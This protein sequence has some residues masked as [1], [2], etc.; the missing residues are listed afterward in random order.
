V[1]G[2][3]R[4][5]LAA[6][7]LALGVGALARSAHAEAAPASPVPAPAVAES[8]PA[9]DAADETPSENDSDGYTPPAEGPGAPPSVVVGGYVDVGFARAQGDGTSFAPGDTRLPADYG[10]D[11][12]ATAVNSRGDVASTDSHG[13]LVNGFLPHSVGIG[14]HPSFLVNTV[15]ADLKYAPPSTPLTMFTRVLVLP[16][17]SDTGDATRVVVEQAFGR[18]IPFDALEAA[19]AVGKF[20]S[21]FGIE[22][23][24]NESNIRTGITPSLIARYTTGQSVGAKLF[25]RQQIAPLWS[26]LSINAAVTNQGTFVDALQTPDVSLTGVPVGSV[27]LGYE[28]NLRR[29]QAKLGA[30]GMY[31]PRNDQS[32]KNATQRAEGA[33][34]RIAVAGLYLNAEAVKVDEDSG[35]PKT[36]DSGEHPLASGFHGRGFYGQLA[37]AWALDAGPLHKLTPYARYEQRHAWFDGFT[38]ITVDR[39]TAGL[40]VDLWESVIVKAE[41]LVNRELAGA[42]N[43]AN[44]VQTASVVYSW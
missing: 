30:S 32:D 42:P 22:Y 15:A 19:L 33:D 18:V 25:F 7:G 28:L 3:G 34:L 20:D 12:F 23:L 35:G 14:G 37:Y 1:T 43:V 13:L 6:W 41:M 10:V 8:G 40:R 26:A 39:I 16:R 24:D 5:A 27:R 38:P 36:N 2:A 31:G 29:V 11:T 21:V 9:P 4:R 17:F 44:N